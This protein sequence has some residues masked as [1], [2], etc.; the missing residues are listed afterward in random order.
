MIGGVPGLNDKM[1]EGTSDKNIP[2]SILLKLT[3]GSTGMW[4]S[5]G[6]AALI[7]LLKEYSSQGVKHIVLPSYLCRSIPIACKTAGFTYSYYSVGPFLDEIK[8]DQSKLPQRLTLVINYF[9]FKNHNHV[10]GSVIED[11]THS[12]L[13]R[14]EFRKNAAQFFSVRKTGPF[15][16]GGW[17][18]VK[19]G[20]HQTHS[21][22][23]LQLFDAE[24]KQLHKKYDYIKS[25]GCDLVTETDYLR[26]RKDLEVFLDAFPEVDRLPE[27]GL[28]L[29]SRYMW[30]IEAEKRRENWKT[31]HGRLSS[32]GYSFHNDLPS[33]VV[34]FGYVLKLD[35]SSR[36]RIRDQLA[37]KRIYCPVHWPL[38]EDVNDLN[39]IKLSASLLTLPL[40][41]RYNEIQ[42]SV[43]CQELEALLK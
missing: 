7:N 11:C 42:M 29:I 39:A 37:A 31:L 43:L 30:S 5:S 41:S 28:D 21:K 23:L 25:G 12:F 27:E 1:F 22:M 33:D 26:T 2:L 15:P 17:A 40:D 18:T 38:S 3:R 13:S 14:F 4:Y 24:L 35:S 6:R 8:F 10:A 32:Q 20:G 34:P 19:C 9:G 16:L 36:N